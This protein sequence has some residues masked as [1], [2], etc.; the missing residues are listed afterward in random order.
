MPIELAMGFLNEFR[1]RSAKLAEFLTGGSSPDSHPAVSELML[2][3]R[4]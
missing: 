2:R 3:C 1:D 4:R